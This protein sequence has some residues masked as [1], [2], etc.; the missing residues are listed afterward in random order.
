MPELLHG[1]Q[2]RMGKDA[3]RDVVRLSADELDRMQQLAT[4][5][6]IERASLLGHMRLSSLETRLNQSCRTSVKTCLRPWRYGS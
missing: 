2:S 4:A 6:K 1:L 5:S 3:R